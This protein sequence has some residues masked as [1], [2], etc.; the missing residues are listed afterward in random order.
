MTC[1]K[2]RITGELRSMLRAVPEHYG[3]V[4]E[5]HRAK[6]EQHGAPRS[7]GEEARSRVATPQRTSDQWHSST[8]STSQQ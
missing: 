5:H 1:S 8:R 2:T 7:S 6:L 4:V 3:T